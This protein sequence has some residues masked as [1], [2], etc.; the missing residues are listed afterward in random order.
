MHWRVVDTSVEEIRFSDVWTTRQWEGKRIIDVS[1]TR[2]ATKKNIKR[3]PL[4]CPPHVKRQNKPLSVVGAFYG[5]HVVDTSVVSKIEKNQPK[6][7]NFIR[8][9]VIHTSTLKGFC[10]IWHA[11]TCRD[12]SIKSNWLQWRVK[13]TSALGKSWRL[14]AEGFWTEAACIYVII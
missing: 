9:R 14:K 3:W 7:W 12:T 8:W 4:T 5:W 2:Q 1:G 10:C 11:L 6:H 13:H